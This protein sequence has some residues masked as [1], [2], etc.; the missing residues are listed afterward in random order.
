[1]LRTVG[2][3]P[4]RQRMALGWL[5]FGKGDRHLSA[6]M[7]YEE[8]TRARCRCRWPPSTTRCTSSPRSGCCA[9][10]RSTARNLFRHQSSQPSS[11]LYRGRGRICST[12]RRRGRVGQTAGAAGR[13]RDRAHRRRGAAA[14][15]GRAMADP[16]SSRSRNPVD[17]VTNRSSR[18]TLLDL[19]ARIDAPQH[20]RSTQPS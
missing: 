17:R 11:L 1:M 18:F 3:R 12:S 19:L 20:V 14:P 8:A 4:T 13:L 10:S 7:L 9:R 16:G 15:Q 5:L 2:L 6:E